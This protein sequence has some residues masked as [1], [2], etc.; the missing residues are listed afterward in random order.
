MALT[1][2]STQGIK[3]GTIT[4][5]DLATNI[6]LVDNQRLRL[7]TGNDLEI[8]HNNDNSFINDTGTGQLMIQASGLRLR[9]YP[10]GHTQVNCQD[11]VVELYYD[12]S[13]KFET[14][15]A[16][17]TVTGSLTVTDDIT[18]QDDLFMGDQDTIKLGDSLD[19]QIQH[20]GTDSHIK[21]LSGETRIQCANIFK[22]TNYQNTETY[23]KGSLNGS[24]ELYHDNSKKFETTASGVQILS[25]GT[26]ATLKIEQQQDADSEAINIRQFG[27]QNQ[28]ATIISFLNWAGSEFGSIE[29]AQGGAVSYTTHDNGKFISGTGDDL[30]IYH[31]GTNNYIEGNNQKTIIRNT[32][33]NIHLQAVSGEAGI[34]ILP[35]SAVKLYH[36]GNQKLETSS[37]GVNV[38]GNFNV[39]DGIMVITHSTPSINFEDNSGSNGNDFAIQVNTNAFKIV[40]TDN[41]NRMG[42]Q[43]GSDGNTALG[44]NVTISG[45]ILLGTHLDMGD[46]DVIKL[47]D[48]DD[49]QI[50]H[51]GSH[52]YI[53]DVGTGKL[54]LT[55]NS[56]R[57]LETDNSTAMIAADQDG[58][59]ELYHDGTK[60][61]ETTS[62]GAALIGS[63]R[64]YG[65]VFP[66]ADNDVDLG[67]TSLRWRN[68]YTHDLNLSNE[69]G[70]NDVDGT[71]GSYTIQEGA[72]D[73]FLVNK[74]NGKKY[75]FNL[76]EVL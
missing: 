55:T 71:W 44:G 29:S 57:L 69:G 68:I 56:F 40:D 65:H 5:S 34:D 74:R 75:K 8:F 38:T 63:L 18:L 35:N 60:R 6:D 50:Y 47:G 66:N 12:N 14:T 13:K 48:G 39:N 52:S 46:S 61:F 42:F 51:D 33:N 45:S 58:A 20:D 26:G 16:G 49:L 32:S 15:S 27:N 73:L 59:V 54:R 76:T 62:Y 70:S 2:I 19:L 36:N 17:A 23:I 24:V 25:T 67:T 41:S 37:V 43:F 53:Q 10:E 7:G 9:N 31:D 64:S 3:D 22:V 4:G 1:Q 21:N 72:E 30:Q 28:A 11:D